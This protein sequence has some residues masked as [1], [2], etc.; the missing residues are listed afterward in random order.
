MDPHLFV[1]FGATGDLTA[2]KL[3]PALFHLI[4]HD[5]AHRYVVLGVGGTALDDATFRD[6]VREAL[7][8]AGL[9]SRQVQKW[10]DD[11]VHYQQVDRDE[12]LTALAARIA[13]IERDHDLAGN[14]VF[15]LALPPGA[16]PSTIEHLGEAGLATSPGWTRLVIEKPFG[17]DLD[18]AHRL[19]AIVHAHFAED[20]V[21][22]I[23]HYL[24]KET[25]QNL[26]AF[27]FANSVFES[28]WNRDRIERVEI[29]V[30]E[31]DGTGGRAGFY[32]QAGAVRDILQNHLT[33]VLALVAMEP[34]VSA[35]ATSVR[36]EKVKVLRSVAPMAREDVVLGQYTGG[37]VSGNEVPGYREEEGTAP[38]SAVSTFV[39]LRLNIDNWR[40]QGVPFLLRT[41]KRLPRRLTQIAVRF[42][43][44]PVSFFDTLSGDVSD[45]V[46]RVT[47]Q[48]EEGFELQIDVKKPGERMALDTIPLSFQYAAK[49]GQIPDAYETLL[50]DVVSGD[51]TLFVRADEVEESWRVYQPLLEPGF[52]LHPY[53]AGTWG[54]RA[55]LQLLEDGDDWLSQ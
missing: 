39:A 45:N 43:R 2:R 13:Q 4:S 46:L 33:Q 40:W 18:S 5:D 48:P 10:C 19:N 22:R 53:A 50:R 44:P 21:Y 28:M 35:D 15:Y 24:G 6:R 47:L 17:R 49:F 32:E 27:R 55:R 20:Q 31:S 38:D 8:A 14:R 1:I 23:D 7:V 16:F 36:N 9:S 34:P 52:D 25:V 37:V 30:A 42:R 26:M 41:G 54:P 29:T 11:C 51:Q 12:D 3:L